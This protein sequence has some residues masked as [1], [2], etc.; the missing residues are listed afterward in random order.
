MAEYTA[1]GTEGQLGA[2]CS[3]LLEKYYP[4]LKAAEYRDKITIFSQFDGESLHDTWNRYQNLLR[5][6]PHHGLERWLVLQTFYK[7]LTPQTRSFVDS[8]SGGGI[9]NKTL[10]EAFTLIKSIASHNVQWASERSVP[11]QKPGMY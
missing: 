3:S 10:N 7:G 11:Q 6:C 9:M 5:M 8:S 4:P 2:P 1:F